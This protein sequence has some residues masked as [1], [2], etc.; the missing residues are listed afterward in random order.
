MTVCI[1]PKF[2]TISTPRAWGNKWVGDLIIGTRQFLS[3][4]SGNGCES[5]TASYLWGS[6]SVLSILHCAVILQLSKLLGEK[7]QCVHHPPCYLD[8]P[9]WYPPLNHPPRG[10]QRPAGAPAL[11][12][13]PYSDLSHV[14]CE[15]IQDA[16][17]KMRIYYGRLQRDATNKQYHLP[18]A[19]SIE[20][21]AQHYALLLLRL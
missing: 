7:D 3:A 10:D 1:I 17:L 5:C 18:F 6:L 21:T 9:P 14:S 12:I 19:I 11:S 4:A 20:T 15:I 13:L 2:Q 16:R 8:P